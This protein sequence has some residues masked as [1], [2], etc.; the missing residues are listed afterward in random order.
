MKGTMSEMELSILRQRAHEAKNLK[1]QRGELVLT[2]AVGYRRVAHGCIEK[3]PDL[4]VQHAIDLVFKK[5]AELQSIRQVH[6]W[7]RRESI[8]LPSTAYGSEGRHVVW[9]LPVY[10]SIH[11][12]LTN[13]IYAGAYAYGRTTHR[14]RLED[15]RKRVVRGC[16]QA[17]Q[18][19]PVLLRD[20]HE[21]YLSWAEYEKNQQLI[22]NNAGNKGLMV[23]RA[24]D[25]WTRQ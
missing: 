15:G 13:P 21:G 20:H 7:L 24:D 3:E 4:R 14:T 22:A 12:I 5:F 1:A 6:R 23:R 25:V 10:A 11:G 2:I 18:D 17:Q 19:W 16:R 8:A 9:K